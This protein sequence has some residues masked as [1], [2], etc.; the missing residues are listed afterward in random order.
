[1]ACVWCWLEPDSTVVSPLDFRVDVAKSPEL[2]SLEAQDAVELPCE[3]VENVGEVGSWGVSD[4]EIPELD[5]KWLPECV[6]DTL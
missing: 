3:F 6:P 4:M 2:V 1:M 5:G